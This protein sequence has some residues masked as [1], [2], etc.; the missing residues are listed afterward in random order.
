MWLFACVC[1]CVCLCAYC[2]KEERRED[3]NSGEALCF[4]H[5]ML[6]LFH[7]N[8]GRER[9]KERERDGALGKTARHTR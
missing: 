5:I 1:V 3:N 9:T 2:R 4:D 7:M 8:L 6:E